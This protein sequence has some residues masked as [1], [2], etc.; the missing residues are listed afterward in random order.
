MSKDDICYSGFILMKYE[1]AAADSKDF[2]SVMFEMWLSC[3]SVFLN[4]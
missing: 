3:E 2:C 1:S 4:G